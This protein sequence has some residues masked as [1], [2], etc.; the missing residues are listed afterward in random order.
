MRKKLI[1]RLRRQKAEAVGRM[2][3]LHKAAQ[4][5]KRELTP[6]ETEEYNACKASADA[7]A[8]SIEEAESLSEDTGQED[9]LL[10][11][12]EQRERTRVE[13]IN[14]RVRLAG[15]GQDLA[16]ALIKS[17]KSADEASS[18]IFQ[19]LAEKDKP[20]D[21]ALNRPTGAGVNKDQRDKVREGLHAALMHRSNPKGYPIK[22][23]L[24][25]EYAGMSLLRMAEEAL[26]AC[27]VK[28]RGLTRDQMVTA[29]LFGMQGGAEYFAGMN[30]GSD[31]PNILADVANKRLRQAYEAAPR[32]FQ[33]FCRQVTAPD[34]KNINVTQLSDVSKFQ[35]VNDQGEFKSATMSDGKETYALATYGEI[36]RITRKT[37]IND[38]LR[39]FDRAPAAIGAAASR[40]ENE[41]VWGVITTNAAMADNVALFHSTHKN[42]NT[43]S[44]L[45]LAGL[46]TMRT[47]LRKQTGPKGVVLN[48]TPKFCIVP[49][50]LEVTGAQL[51]SPSYLAASSVANTIPDFIR[52]MSL[53]V[54]PLLDADSATT[55][56]GACDPSQ[57]DTI[58]FAYLEGQE[59]VYT[60]MRT[61][62]EVDGI[63]IK[64]RLDF[65]AAAIDYRGLAKCTA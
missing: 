11:A 47:A 8:T 13:A 25:A 29:A 53:I 7:F 28:V 56:Y 60:E 34:F 61:G 18:E 43:S 12:G 65:A 16:D 26:A 15:L 17:G 49:A 38:D 22:D 19:K 20:N 44:A 35:K 51:L 52:S 1:E 42:L 27:G 14:S 6:E 40:L 63:E 2:E 32:T 55:W 39:A 62:F 48:L 33:A 57:I 30:T 5:A 50:A 36:L 9:E 23:G 24:G 59:G 54:E 3:A 64:G 31:F 41:T 4:K 21:P 46:G 58:E 45:A 10:R 37:I